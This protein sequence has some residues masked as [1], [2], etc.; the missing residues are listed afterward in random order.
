MTLS[1]I[2]VGLALVG[3]FAGCGEPAPGEKGDPGLTGDKGDKGEKGEKGEPGM[4]GTVDPAVSL[5]T[6]PSLFAGRNAL[7]QV[8]G[9]ST[10][11]AAGSTVDFGDAAIK[12]NKVEAG[13]NANLRISVTVGADAKLGPHDV[14]VAS[15]PTGAM[16]GPET[17]TLKG[18]FTVLPSLAMEAPPMG[19]MVATAPQGGLVDIAVK[20][21]DLRENPFSQ[22]GITRFTNGASSVGTPSTRTDRFAVLALVDALAPAGGLRVSV[23][24]GDSPDSLTYY[25]SDPSDAAAIKVTARMATELKAGMAVASQSIGAKNGTVLYKLTT[26]AD[27]SVVQLAFTGLG[28]GLSG[29]ASP[30]L[31]GAQAPASGKFG[32]GRSFD[33][34]ATPVTMGMGIAARNGFMLLPKMGDAYFSVYASDFSGG[35]THTFTTTAK[36]AAGTALSSLVEPMGG[37]SEMKP[38]ATIMTLDKP[39]F[40]LDGAADAAYDQD[41]I[42]FTPKTTGR[43]YVIVNTTVGV[44]MGLGLRQ[45]DCTSILAASKYSAT[46]TVFNE[47]DVTAGTAYCVRVAGDGKP[48]PYQVII[49]Q[50]LP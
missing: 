29:V 16:G 8:S 36:V 10:H 28:A 13:S 43:V 42:K 12:V 38:I 17:V 37:D 11:F 32:D 15:P 3:F 39:Y 45:G 40:G 22:F 14:T 5:L 46:G 48:T 18:G 35:M 19:T 50:A 23:G 33:T 20:N 25:T 44:S 26:T 30:R 7:V 47:T 49:T 2:T 4:S 34:S 31:I 21:L 24:S 27:N 9:V 1:R 6:P 41:F